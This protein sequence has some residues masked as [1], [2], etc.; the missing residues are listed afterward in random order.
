MLIYSK[1]KVA[2]E[3]YNLILNHIYQNF[4]LDIMIEL[5]GKLAIFYNFIIHLS[6]LLKYVFFFYYFFFFYLKIVN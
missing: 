4:S 6:V 2:K 1:L 3:S 5:L